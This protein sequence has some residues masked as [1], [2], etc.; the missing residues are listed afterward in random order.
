MSNVNFYGPYN[1]DCYQPADSKSRTWKWQ[2]GDNASYWGFSVRPFDA[3][4]MVQLNSVSTVADNDGVQWTLLTV[5]ASPPP[6]G[7]P[8]I[9]NADGGNLNFTAIGVGP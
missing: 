8:N 5:T 2:L 1:V 9:A 6:A 7:W 3:N 4:N